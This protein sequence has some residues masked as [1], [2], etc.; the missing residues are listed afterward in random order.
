MDQGKPVAA[1]KLVVYFHHGPGKDGR[2]FYGNK[3]RGEKLQ[4]QGCYQK[5][6]RRL[7][8][9][10]KQKFKNTFRQAI[11]YDMLQGG[12]VLEKFENQ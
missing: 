2:I 3:A 6:L 4:D 5:D 7:T 1:L 11:L 8:Y 9:L 12:Q 10:A